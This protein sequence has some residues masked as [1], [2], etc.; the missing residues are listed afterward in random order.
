MFLDVIRKLDKK[1][2]V[3][4][5]LVKCTTVYI[6]IYFLQYLSIV[7]FDKINILEYSSHCLF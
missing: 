7:L 5:L 2:K 1:V 6:Q 4:L 3:C